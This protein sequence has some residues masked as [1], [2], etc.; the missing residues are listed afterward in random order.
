MEV[1]AII[2][3]D[4]MKSRDTLRN[5]LIEFCPEVEILGEARTVKEAVKIILELRPDLVFLDIHL[6]EENGFALFNYFT[7]PFFEIVFTTA[8]DQ[9]AVQ[10]FRLAAIDYLLKPIDVSQ[11]RDA[12][13]KVVQKKDGKGPVPQYELLL[14]NMKADNK[15]IVLPTGN[16][17]SVF[18]P[19]EVMYCEASR[20]YSYF[21]LK[22]KEK[23]I[24][25]KP[26]KVFED[27][28]TDFNFFRINRSFMINIGFLKSYSR[29][30][31][32]EVTLTNGMIFSL[33]PHRREEF[34]RLISGSE[35]LLGSL[36]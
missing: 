8:Y 32:G 12:V 19:Q 31:Q 17:F 33:S 9:Y 11:L 28:L 36:M 24:V 22:N 27:T 6:P 18:D 10:A 30:H 1:R 15:K 4:E 7:K 35:N 23:V 34:L 29:S 5:F 3:E 16:G 26:L 2:V 20:N 21:Y 14:E 25:S 13:K